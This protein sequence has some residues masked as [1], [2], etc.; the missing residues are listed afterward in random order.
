MTLG[1]FA[2]VAG[3]GAGRDS[4]SGGCIAVILR[5]PAETGGAGLGK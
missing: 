2:G 4:Q 1:R 5:S 3:S